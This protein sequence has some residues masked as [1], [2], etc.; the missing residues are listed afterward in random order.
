MH[1]IYFDIK[2]IK[3]DINF[4]LYITINININTS[5]N[6]NVDIPYNIKFIVGQKKPYG[7]SRVVTIT[8]CLWYLL[9]NPN[10]F[11][12]ILNTLNDYY[13]PW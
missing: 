7:S 11:N 1:Y 5:T 12:Q 4:D 3:V 8:K 9:F 10:L 2:I 13:L 6:T